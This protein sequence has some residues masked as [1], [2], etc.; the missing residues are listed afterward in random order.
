[1]AGRRLGALPGREQGL[2]LAAQ[3]GCRAVR[4]RQVV[5]GG[6]LE[7]REEALDGIAGG[8]DDGR[9]VAMVDVQGEGRREEAEAI[10]EPRLGRP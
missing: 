8:R 2:Q 10:L 7:D 1:M 4:I 6:R 9:A 5:P 3:T